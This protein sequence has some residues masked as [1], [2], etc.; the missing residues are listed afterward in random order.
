MPRWPLWCVALCG[1]PPV[2]RALVDAVQADA[3]AIV[4]LFPRRAVGWVVGPRGDVL[5]SAAT[6]GEGGGGGGGPAPPPAA[7]PRR[8]L[9]SVPVFMRAVAAHV[10]ASVGARAVPVVAHVRGGR[11]TVTSVFAAGPRGAAMIVVCDPGPPAA[12]VFD[13]AA[14]D[15]LVLPHLSRLDGDVAALMA[16]VAGGPG[17]GGAALQGGGGGGGGGTWP[18]AGSGGSGTAVPAAAASGSGGTA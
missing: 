10:G 17:G 8:V 1:E 9:P 16:A 2:D 4:A 11:G 14:V 18:D 3:E 7:D 12:A 15:A 13:A 5:A 6:G